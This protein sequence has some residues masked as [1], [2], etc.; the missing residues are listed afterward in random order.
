MIIS[1]GFMVYGSVV[2]SVLRDCIIFEFAFM[3]REV[4][5]ENDF[6]F[7]FPPS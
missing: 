2:F 7:E 6:I 3:L 5:G 1:I 4:A